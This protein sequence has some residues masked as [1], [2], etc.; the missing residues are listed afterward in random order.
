LRKSFQVAPL[1]AGGFGVFVL[2][3]ALGHRE[4]VRRALH[5]NLHSKHGNDCR[6]SKQ[7]GTRRSSFLLAVSRSAFQS[8]LISADAKEAAKRTQNLHPQPA[9]RPD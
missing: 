6:G 8:R 7:K 1:R 2:G 9:T 3:A 5:S 4:R